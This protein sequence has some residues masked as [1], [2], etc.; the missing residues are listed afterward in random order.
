MYC[1]SSGWEAVCLALLIDYHLSILFQNN[2]SKVILSGLK[3]SLRTLNFPNLFYQSFHTEFYD[4][5]SIFYEL[6]LNALY[7]A[8]SVQRLIF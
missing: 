8:K 3:L 7:F 2:I 1:F 4:H 5:S 6:F